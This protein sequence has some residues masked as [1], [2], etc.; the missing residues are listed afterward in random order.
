MPRTVRIVVGFATL[1]AATG[2][3]AVA[4][5]HATT[6]QLSAAQERRLEQFEH[7]TLGP[8]HAAEHAEARRLAAARRA[9]L[10]RLSPAERR[11]LKSRERARARAGIARAAVAGDPATVGKWTTGPASIPVMGINAATLPTGKVLFWAYP[12]NP[13]PVYNPDFDVIGEAPNN[14]LTAVWDPQTGKTKVIPPPINPDT[15][16]R[17]NIWCSGISFLPDG[18][19]LAAGG[20]LGYTPDWKGLKRAY[21]FNPWTETWKE[22]GQ[23]HGGRWYPSQVLLGDG[24]TLVFQGYD[25]TGT[26][27]RNP[28]VDVFDPATGQFSLVG[29][30]GEPGTP[31]VGEYYPHTFLMPSGRVLIAGQWRYDSWMF[32]NPGNDVSWTN[33]PHPFPAFTDRQWGTAVLLPGDHDG[34]TRVMQIGGSWLDRPVAAGGVN[35][36]KTTEVFDEVNFGGGWQYATSMGVGRSHANTV[37]LPDGSMVEIGGGK[38]TTRNGAKPAQYAVSGTEKQVELWDPATGQWRLGPPQVE[39]RAYH[40]TAVLLP[41]GRVVSAGD[42]YNGAGGPGSG[43][44]KDTLEVYSPPY[45]FKGPRP[46][47]HSAPTAVRWNTTFG[48]GTRDTDVTRAILMAPSATTHATD[49]NQ[50]A[51]SLPITKRGDELGYDVTSPLKPT[52]APPGVYML[53]LLNARGVPSVAKWVR[54]DPA[55]PPPPTPTLLPL[56]K[57]PP[58]VP[59]PPDT[60]DRTPPEILSAR[61]S[62]RRI[63]TRGRGKGTTFVLR[64][65]EPASIAIRFERAREGRRVEGRCAKVSRRNHRLRP[66][67]RYVRWG[68]T[69]EAAAQADREARVRFTG[70]LDGRRLPVG[71][72]RVAIVARDAASNRSLPRTLRFRVVRAR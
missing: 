56:P 32:N 20:N 6:A 3:G 16:E 10:R 40:S 15:G 5:A 25:E 63:V 30:I 31:P 68:K 72:W 46:T 8:S 47:I 22:V 12:T 27:T 23:M 48:V 44:S 64:L 19:V 70:A 7:A 58:P 33:I 53:F 14:S 57:P 41:D 36:V 4:L 37:L 29:K 13:N 69:L 51:L 71:R 9:R 28:K 1:L 49:M 34:S 54:L 39:A 17:T 59:P 50:R 24:R 45:L 21:V 18:S 35:A 55:A 60:D 61:M 38:G 26:G 67:T 2:A 66:C 65:S 52:A 43:L 62:K 11:R 42:D